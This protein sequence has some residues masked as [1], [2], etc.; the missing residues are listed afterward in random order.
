MSATSF[1]ATDLPNVIKRYLKAH[2][3][4]DTPA[5]SATLTADAT[6]VDDGHTYEGIP[7]I[8]HWL[9]SAASEYTYTTTLIA[10]ENDGPDR[11]TVTQRLEGDFPGGLVD[12]RYRFTLDQEL[13][14]HL[15]IAP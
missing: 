7:A 10:A 5:A 3:E 13:I 11:Y 4:R 14:S 1:D 9:T 6:V 8:E 15:T 2:T 12:L